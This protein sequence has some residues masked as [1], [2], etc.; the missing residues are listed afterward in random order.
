LLLGAPHLGARLS[1]DAA[2]NNTDPASLSGAVPT[3]ARSIRRTD[4]P[5]QGESG[6]TGRGARRR[7]TPLGATRLGAVL[8]GT[9]EL[10]CATAPSA[11]DKRARSAQF[12]TIWPRSSPR[13]ITWRS[14]AG[15]PIEPGTAWPEVL[16]DWRTTRA[17]PPRSV[18]FGKGTPGERDPQYE[19]FAQLAVRGD[20]PPIE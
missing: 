4:G 5:R 11:H 12:R 16:P 19:T 13:R 17:G 14:V 8:A 20:G 9:G 1:R 2:R 15:H 18:P 3:S 10:I 6:T 7:A